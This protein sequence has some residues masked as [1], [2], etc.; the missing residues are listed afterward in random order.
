MTISESEARL[1]R[2]LTESQ[3]NKPFLSTAIA[4]DVFDLILHEL[5]SKYYGCKINH[6]I[7]D[8]TW[9]AIDKEQI[10][11]A[12]EQHLDNVLDF[13]ARNEDESTLKSFGD[14]L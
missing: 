11:E 7:L 1:W 6:I 2:K 4:H 13:I 10:C 12:I 3:V 8:D 9:D 14:N 5:A